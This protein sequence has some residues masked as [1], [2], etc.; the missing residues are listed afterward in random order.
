MAIQ[1]Q[2]LASC[3]RAQ[4]SERRRRPSFGSTGN[5]YDIVSSSVL[6]GWNR[7]AECRIL[8]GIDPRSRATQES[9]HLSVFAFERRQI[10]LFRSHLIGQASR[11]FYHSDIQML[12]A[13]RVF[14][15]PYKKGNPILPLKIEKLAVKT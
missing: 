6:E 12:K 7:M 8:R 1:Q 11:A 3:S 9:H 5:A 14:N 10:Q 2:R 15:I 4:R 13:L